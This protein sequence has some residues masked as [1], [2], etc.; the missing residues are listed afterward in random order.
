MD[1]DRKIKKLLDMQEHPEQYSEQE[2][3][4]M[5]RDTEAQELM[6]ATAQLKQAMTWERLLSGTSSG[7]GGQELEVHTNK[8][9][10]DVDS[11]WQQ[12][13]KTHFVQ[14]KPKRNWLQVAAMFIGILFVTGFTFAAIHLW[15]HIPRFSP[16]SEGDET[17][18]VEDTVERATDPLPAEEG[19][20]A[21]L[22]VFDNVSLDSIAK[23]IA[24][25]HHLPMEIENDEARQLRFFFE[26]NQKDSLQEVVEKLNMFE[27][28]TM[29][30][31]NGKLMVR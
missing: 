30:V 10:T 16:K 9:T 3:E 17:T 25:Y 12:F 7:M 5:L 19:A 14:S 15:N 26:W 13:A 28:V 29:A 20:E 6:E 21:E 27:H 8:E 18:L 1:R 23:D 4:L 2:L 11:E 22:I 31:E 24:A